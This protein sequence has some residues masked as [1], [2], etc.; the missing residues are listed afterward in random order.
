MSHLGSMPNGNAYDGRRPSNADLPLERQTQ[1]HTRY[2]TALMVILACCLFATYAVNWVVDPLAFGSLLGHDVFSSDYRYEREVRYNTL[3]SRRPEVVILGTS[4]TGHGIDP[5]NPL[6]GG[7]LTAY[8]A[9]ISGGTSSEILRIMRHITELGSVRRVVI[10]IDFMLTKRQGGDHFD[11]A[12][13]ASGGMEGWLKAAKARLS[14][15][16]L[17]SSFKQVVEKLTHKA[18]YADDN[19]HLLPTRFQAALR[20][21][22]GPDGAILNDV[23]KTTAALMGP[24]ADFRGDLSEIINLACRNHIDLTL[25]TPPSHVS[26]LELLRITGRWA[27]FESWERFANEAASSAPCAVTVWSFTQVNALTTEIVPPPGTMC[28]MPDYWDMVHYRVGLGNEMLNEMF[29]DRAQPDATTPDVRK[30]SVETTLGERLTP[31]NLAAFQRRREVALAAY[32]TGHPEQYARIRA[33]AR[34]AI[35]N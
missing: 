30:I 17:I 22:G 4:Q 34:K 3:T 2:L 8:N 29:G 24:D 14:T 27:A 32:D 31:G 1:F 19:G 6:L 5:A 21:H 12:F 7:P 26:V 20:A 35:G 9:S 33:E 28:P 23:D 25:F 15:A 18:S 13:L 10:G 11:D 16:M